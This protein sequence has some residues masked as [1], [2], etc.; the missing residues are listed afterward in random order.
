[1]YTQKPL[2]EDLSRVA[3]G[4]MGALSGLRNEMES[5]VRQQM[6]RLTAGMDLVRREEFEVV[7]AMAVKARAENEALA[8]RIAALEAKLGVAAD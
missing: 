7:Q 6:E 8:K 3:G 4:A 2:F 1:M 5:L